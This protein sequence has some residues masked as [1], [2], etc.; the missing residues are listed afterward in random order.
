MYDWQQHIVSVLPDIPYC[1]VLFTMPGNL[2]DIVRDN[3]HLLNVLPA[4]AANVLQEWADRK[5]NARVLILAVPHTFGGRLNLNPHMHLI[6][7]SVGLDMSGKYL[8]RD[9]PWTLRYVQDA[10]VRKWRDAVLDYLLRALN[11]GAIV[12]AR[13]R[14]QLKML[15]E[16]HKDRQWYGG[17]RQCRSV[18]SLCKYMTRYLRRLPIGQNRLLSY[19]GETIRFSFKDKKSMTKKIQ[20]YPVRQYIDLLADQV[21][22]RYRHAVRYF[23][24]LAPRSKG[25]GYKVFLALLNQKRRPRSRRTSWPRLMWM[26]FRRDPL[27]SANGEVFQRRGWNAPNGLSSAVGQ[28]L[29]Q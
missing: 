15:F 3:R 14:H 17:I 6:V 28:I 8:V 20:Q 26:T 1:G 23:G 18:R 9:I 16:G 4:L 25:R 19:D 10:L 11:L 5:F 22:D 24:L 2:W 27:L 13:P 12:S 29:R 21:P 7:S